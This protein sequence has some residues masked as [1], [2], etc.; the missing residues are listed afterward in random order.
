MLVLERLGQEDH[1]FK[2]SMDHI[3]RPVPKPKTNKQNRHK[4]LKV[5]LK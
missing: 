3:A 1:K 5:Q 2:S 4:G